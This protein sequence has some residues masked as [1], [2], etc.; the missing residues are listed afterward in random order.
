M[1][2]LEILHGAMAEWAKSIKYVKQCTGPCVGASQV[3][4][5]LR[6][7]LRIPLCKAM[8]LRKDEGSVFLV[9]NLSDWEDEAM[10]Q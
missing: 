10:R 6:S 7:L 1:E 4:T 8:V 9:L 2:M 5:G 3:G